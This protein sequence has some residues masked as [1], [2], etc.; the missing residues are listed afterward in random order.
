MTVTATAGCI[1]AP[2]QAK[3][4]FEQGFQV[5]TGRILKD[6][7]IISPLTMEKRPMKGTILLPSHFKFA[8]ILESSCSKPAWEKEKPTFVT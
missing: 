5:F 1:A 6:W 8:S 2:I 7:N 3:Y 4:T